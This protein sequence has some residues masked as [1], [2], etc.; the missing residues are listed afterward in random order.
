MGYLKSGPVARL[1][2]IALSGSCSLAGA[3]ITPGQV[4]DTLKPPPELRAP[5]RVEPVERTRP[6]QPTAPAAGKTFSVTGFEFA[7]NTVYSGAD[8]QALVADYLNRPIS[9]LDLYAAADRIAEHYIAKGYTLASVTVPPQKIDG[10]TVRL[11][12][13]EGRIGA[14]SAENNQVYRFHQLRAYLED[15][16]PGSPYRSADL[17]RGLRAL[18][19]LPG[20][21]V[22]AV[23]RP[24]EAYGTSDLVLRTE[25]KAVEGSLTLD[26]YGR[27]SIGEMRLSAVGQ[28]NN[29][30]GAEDQL[31]LMALASEDGLLKYGYGAYSLPITMSGTRLAFS[32]GHAQFEVEDAPLEGRNHSARVQ[33]EH[34]LVR[35]ASDLLTMTVGGSYTRAN[36]DFATLFLNETVVTLFELGGTYSHIYANAAISQVSL[37]F[38]TNFERLT[39]AELVAAA[40]NG[41][42][43]TGDQR[44]RAELD[45]QHVQ[46]LYRGLQLMLRAN[47]VY[48]PDPLADTQQYSLGGPNSIRGF[49]ASEIR[50]DRGYFG[51]VTLRQPFSLGPL[52]LYGRVFA[53]SGV[54]TVVDALPGVSERETL[55]SAGVGLDAQ[56]SHL[57]MKLDWSFPCD[58]HTISDGEDDQRLFGSVSLRF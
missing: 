52:K 51:Q 39:R 24:G 13:S 40:T 30:L 21:K 41:T 5:E 15:V 44:I 16:H 48:S 3:Q 49:P 11:L 42:R 26:N 22:R 58:N 25:E 8:L 56:W 19:E 23:V 50:G 28:I 32:Y 2:A 18:N 53:D 29:P 9:L 37:N 36:S 45:L 34:P 38:A 55:T 12:V 10:G 20:L 14:I 57:A 17:E 43:L 54:V 6:A 7:G 33:I 31:Q 1:L 35:S 46:P 4:G 47:G 27:D